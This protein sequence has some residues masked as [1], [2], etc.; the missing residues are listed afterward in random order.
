MSSNSEA[1]FKVSYSSTGI[2]ILSTFSD[3]LLT[4][5]SIL[6]YKKNDLWGHW[7]GLW[8]SFESKERRDYT[9]IRWCNLTCCS[10]MVSRKG[11]FEVL[12]FLF[13]PALDID[14]KKSFY[15]QKHIHHHPT[16]QNTDEATSL[17]INWG[18]L[19]QL[20]NWETLKLEREPD[21]TL[22]SC[23]PLRPKNIYKTAKFFRFFYRSLLRSI[24]LYLLLTD[25]WPS[26]SSR[27]FFPER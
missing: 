10:E 22:S 7:S 20:E 24:L 5:E 19:V 14:T 4:L 15:T 1:I 16:W 12:F 8:G 3:F 13:S 23:F 27:F 11:L 26:S 25:R 2:N 9:G 17:K 6:L 21:S 18:W